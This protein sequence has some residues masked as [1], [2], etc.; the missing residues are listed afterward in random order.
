MEGRVV[1]P[2]T[3]DVIVINDEVWIER[4]RLKCYLRATNT[5]VYE[6]L[7]TAIMAYI[8]QADMLQNYQWAYISSFEGSLNAAQLCFISSPMLR[9]ALEC[10]LEASDLF[11][12]EFF[13]HCFVAAAENFFLSQP[14]YLRGLQ[15]ALTGQ[16]C[17]VASNAIIQFVQHCYVS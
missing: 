11:K 14:A 2:V 8:S 4:P 3:R 13:Q 9:A 15:D 1:Y 16:D 12:G 17:Y 6:P 5:G 7:T 10:Y